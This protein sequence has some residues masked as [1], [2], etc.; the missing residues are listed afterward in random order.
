M[1]AIT[2]VDLAKLEGDKEITEEQKKELGEVNVLWVGTHNEYELT[3]GNN[4]A[5]IKKWLRSHGHIP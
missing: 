2:F 5:T 1:V 4:K 3:F